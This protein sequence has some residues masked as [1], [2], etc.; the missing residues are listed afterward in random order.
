M[1]I[2][3]KK[4][5]VTA[6]WRSV[7]K[8]ALRPRRTACTSKRLLSIWM[9]RKWKKFRPA[10]RKARCRSFPSTKFRRRV[11]SKNPWRKKPHRRRK[12]LHPGPR[13]PMRRKSPSSRW[14]TNLQSLMSQRKRRRSL[15]QLRLKSIFR[16]SGMT[17]LRSRRMSRR[18]KPK[19]LAPPGCTKSPR[20]RKTRPSKRFAST[21]RTACLSRRWP[22]W[23]NSRL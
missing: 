10:K 8:S 1:R 23:P 20:V 4:P 18:R 16:R 2:I 22:R 17:L 14:T 12:L 5:R 19:S 7:M 6:N 15:P 21:W 13:L 3:R 9:R 11:R